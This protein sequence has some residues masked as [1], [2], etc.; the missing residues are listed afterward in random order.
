MALGTQAS[1]VD[2]VATTPLAGTDL[3]PDQIAGPVQTATAADVAEQRRARSRGFHEPAPE[4]RV[5]QRNAG[6]TR[7]SPT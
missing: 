5:S 6:R 4:R 1:K 2:V 3:A 7:S